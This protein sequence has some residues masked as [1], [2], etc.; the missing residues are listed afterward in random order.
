MQVFKLKLILEDRVGVV[1]D[2]GQLVL[3]KPDAD[4]LGVQTNLLSAS[5]PKSQLWKHRNLADIDEQLVAVIMVE[6]SL[7]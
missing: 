5:K 6:A 3:G 2:H 1:V 7:S 4:A